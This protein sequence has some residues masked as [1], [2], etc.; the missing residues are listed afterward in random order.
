MDL[1]IAADAENSDS[2]HMS[3]TSN[4]T[5]TTS[6][7][8][9]DTIRA[10]ASVCLN[11]AL[12]SNINETVDEVIPESS[13]VQRIHRL[14][15]C[16]YCRRKFFSSQALGGHQNAHKRERTMAKRAMKIGLF[17]R[18]LM[19]LPMHNSVFRTMGLEAH[20]LTTH[21]QTLASQIPCVDGNSI[22]EQ[23]GY[24]EP[25]IFAED[26][27]EEMMPW[28]GSFRP[29]TDS[30]YVVKE[31]ELQPVTNSAATDTPAQS[32]S[33]DLTLRL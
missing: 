12:Q 27:V 23:C 20:A 21:S 6:F 16:N 28:P 8:Y 10:D 31:M 13:Q 29:D 1:N 3:E 2:E 7:K 9:Q 19:S 24:F 18:N 26:D 33:P 11:S 30:N 22:R 4:Q 15:S 17:S 14:F 5:C 25:L 32:V